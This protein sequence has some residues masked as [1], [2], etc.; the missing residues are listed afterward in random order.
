MRGCLIGLVLIGCGGSSGGCGNGDKAK[1]R[2]S[3]TASGNS[4]EIRDELCSLNA[5]AKT[6]LNCTWST[7]DPGVGYVEYWLEGEEPQRTPMGPEGT[8]HEVSVLGMRA[9]QTWKY[10]VF[11]DVGTEIMGDEREIETPIPPII[12]PRN[13]VTQVTGESLAANGYILTAVI[14]GNSSVPVIVDGEGRYVWWYE[15]PAG[16]LVVST[17]LSMDGKSVLFATYDIKWRE[18]T[19]TIWRV[20]LDGKEEIQTNAFMGHHDFLEHDDA[21]Y[22]YIGYDFRTYGNTYWSADALRRV[23][24]GDLSEDGWTEEFNWF[25]DYPYADEPWIDDPFPDPIA[26]GNADE[27]WTHSNSLMV[28]G[29]GHYY[30][31]SKFL[32]AILKIDP[33]DGSVIWQMGG[34]YSDFD[35][36]SGPMWTGLSDHNQW[37]H[38]HMSDMRQGSL[39][40]FDNNYYDLDGG[41]HSRAVEYTYDEDNLIVEEV[42]SYSEPA[43]GFSKLMGDVRKLD[44]T[45]LI[46]WSSIGYV[47]EVNA[48]KEIVW[49]MDLVDVHDDDDIKDAIVSRITLLDDLYDPT[50]R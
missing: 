4:G 13:E 36:P 18:D 37:S 31:M 11:T 24:K 39:S 23:E 47:S 6:V 19:G 21:T 14:K 10:R 50:P 3:D 38:A 26:L 43:G 2:D 35:L 12:F 16:N 34:R 20:S 8:T 9:G 45:Y 42:W 15:I 28:N 17:K 29:D 40:M 22:T 1:D 32:D 46:N 27:E 7:D 25:D 41:E 33:D 49:R 5:K 30:L 48:D 44:T